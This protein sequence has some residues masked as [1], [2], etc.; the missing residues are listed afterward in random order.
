MSSPASLASGPVTTKRASAGHA[1]ATTTT[2]P[3]AA[4]PPPTTP[5]VAVSSTVATAVALPLQPASPSRSKPHHQQQSHASPVAAAAAAKNEQQA[6]A[7]TQQTGATG[8]IAAS[9]S[10]SASASPSPPPAPAP[11]PAVSLPSSSAPPPSHAPGD[12][13]APPHVKPLQLAQSNKQTGAN[14][15]QQQQQP[16]SAGASRDEPAEPRASSTL[17]DSGTSAAAASV[18]RRALTSMSSAPAAP[19]SWLE[20][21]AHQRATS[22]GG[23]GAGATSDPSS[24]AGSPVHSSLAGPPSSTPLL[25]GDLPPSESLYMQGM[26]T[27]KGRNLGFGLGFW[28]TTRLYMLTD[29]ALSYTDK[30]KKSVKGHHLVE[31]FK[32]VTRMNSRRWPNRCFTLVFEDNKVWHLRAPTPTECTDWLD[33]MSK[34]I[35]NAA[36]RKARW[37]FMRDNAQMQQMQQMQQMGVQ[38]QYGTMPMGMGMAQQ[39]IDLAQ[40]G[41]M[42][43]PMPPLSP[44]SGGAI[45]PVPIAPFQMHPML[46]MQ[47]QYAQMGLPVLPMHPAAFEASLQHPY[48]DAMPMPM[49]LA[50]D[51]S[52]M[53]VPHAARLKSRSRTNL[54]PPSSSALQRHDSRSR[55]AAGAVGSGASGLSGAAD[56]GALDVDG[57]MSSDD[58]DAHTE[59]ETDGEAEG[60]DEGEGEGASEAEGECDFVSEMED[61]AYDAG[62]TPRFLPSAQTMAAYNPYTQQAAALNA[63]TFAQWTRAQAQQMADA[64]LFNPAEQA[65]LN[66]AKDK[67]GWAMAL[68]SMVGAAI[69]ILGHEGRTSTQLFGMVLGVFGIGSAAA[70]GS[71]SASG[72]GAV[73]ALSNATSNATGGIFSLPSASL[74]SSSLSFLPSFGAVRWS[75]VLLLLSLLAAVYF[76]LALKKHK[77]RSKKQ[78]QAEKAAKAAEKKEQELQRARGIT[79]PVNSA[80]QQQEWKAQSAVLAK[81]L[82]QATRL[83]SGLGASAALCVATAAYMWRT[84]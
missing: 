29:T 44:S 15:Q 83:M 33:S 13:A 57:A 21:P 61:E 4:V 54:Q 2:A 56:P 77:A 55:G 60:A 62:V 30:T 71:A 3:A 81:E 8:V 9:A 84:A 48:A 39:Q 16:L 23:A 24:S 38:T 52:P 6:Q 50:A 63:A 5:T 82:A 18:H 47:A 32:S 72:S 69:L 49:Q 26:L 36:T 74:L 80:A 37:R 58:A 11:A 17:S 79:V 40:M 28:R 25:H 35:A 12:S 45:M 70:A 19:D 41:M 14:A 27:K 75:S 22:A 67:L 76:G 73:V 46:A 34:A 78:R 66:A 43:M 42:Q 68:L 31:E 53:G 20:F 59:D 65:A 1:A 7:Q 64:A 51:S 10:A